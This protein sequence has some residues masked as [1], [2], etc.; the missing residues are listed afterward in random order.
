MKKTENRHGRKSSVDVLPENIKQIFLQLLENKTLSYRDISGRIQALGY[1]VSK[2]SIG[3]YKF[4][5]R[6]G[7]ERLNNAGV[8]S[9]ISKAHKEDFKELAWLLLER[10]ILNHRSQE[11]EQEIKRLKE[12]IPCFKDVFK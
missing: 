6:H 10:E 9:A 7:L 11:K 1:Y 5:L 3:R 2:S 8:P 4:R 12:K